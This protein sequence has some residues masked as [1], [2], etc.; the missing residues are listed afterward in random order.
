MLQNSRFV[1][2]VCGGVRILL[3]AMLCYAFEGDCHTL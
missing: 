2:F 3:R 1:S